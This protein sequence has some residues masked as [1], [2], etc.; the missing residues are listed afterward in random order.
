MSLPHS[1]RMRSGPNTQ[2]SHPAGLP[3][4]LLLP[5]GKHKHGYHLIPC[6]TFQMVHL[7]TPDS[8]QHSNS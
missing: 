3:H 7:G 6:L 4:S 1:D 8:A 2:L 5:E